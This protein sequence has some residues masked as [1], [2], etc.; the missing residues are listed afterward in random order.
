MR[1]G[2][3]GKSSAPPDQIGVAGPWLGPGPL[4]METHLAWHVARGQVD[5]VVHSNA[6]RDRGLDR[7]RRGAGQDIG[8]RA[9]LCADGTGKRDA[10][11]GQ[12][13][14]PVTGRPLLGQGVPTHLQPPH[15]R[16]LRGGK[17][18]G[19]SRCGLAGRWIAAGR[20]LAV[21]LWQ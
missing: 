1:P 18:P 16:I 21:G 19:A 3:S 2:H 11:R 10:L 17:L 6:H 9:E 7:A 20:R 12:M 14:A 15:R 8:D 4:L 5:G 13:R